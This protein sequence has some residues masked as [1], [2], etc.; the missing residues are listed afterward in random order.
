MIYIKEKSIENKIKKF[1]ELHNHYYIKVHGSVYQKVGTPDILGCIDGRFVGIEVKQEN[2][3]PST[4]QIEII[5]KIK[6]TGGLALIVYSFE[7]FKQFYIEN[8]LKGNQ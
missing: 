4:I 1:L 2:G 6:K 3:R 5:E 7:D 8:F